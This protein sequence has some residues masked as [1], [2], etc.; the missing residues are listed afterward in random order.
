VLPTHVA[1]GTTLRGNREDVIWLI[2]ANGKIT[3]LEGTRW[4]RLGA[5]QG[6]LALPAGAPQAE[7]AGGRG[8]GGGRG[9]RQGTVGTL[10][11]WQMRQQRPDVATTRQ[12]GNRRIVTWLVAV[13]GDAPLKLAV[14]SQK[15]G[16]QSRDLT[17]Q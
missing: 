1:S 10:A 2:G 9:G 6:T 13:E 7:V 5:L 3:F 11:L 14:T 8:G 16:T 4:Q 17:I 15:G 12:T